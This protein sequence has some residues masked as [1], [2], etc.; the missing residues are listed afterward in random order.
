[1]RVNSLTGI[2]LGF[3]TGLFGLSQFSSWWL[4]CLDTSDMLLELPSELIAGSHEAAL[5]QDRQA[6]TELI[7]RIK[8]LAPETAEG[9]RMLVD[10]FQLGQIKELL[11]DKR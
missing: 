8:S 7:G 6:L 4:A 9:L 5:V 3:S 2:Q 10:G 11:R 1:M